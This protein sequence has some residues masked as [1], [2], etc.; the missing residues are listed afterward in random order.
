MENSTLKTSI[1]LKR[2]IKEH[3]DPDF[4]D[5][6]DVIDF[7]VYAA[8]RG[9]DFTKGLHSEEKAYEVAKVGGK[10][11]KDTENRN[12]K[13]NSLIDRLKL[14]D[15]FSE[16]EIVEVKEFIVSYFEDWQK[17]SILS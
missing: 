15:E 3:T 5:Y 6:L 11:H 16:Q 4:K 14:S 8:L 7:A 13:I 17:K 2:Y 1:A 9:K 10:R 12:Y